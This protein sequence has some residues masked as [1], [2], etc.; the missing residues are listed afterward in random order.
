MIQS[1]GEAEQLSLDY[2]KKANDYQ[3]TI[4]YAPCVS[5]EKFLDLKTEQ[6]AKQN[7]RAPV[8]G[9]RRCFYLL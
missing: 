4:D 6:K 7:R 5:A 3:T 8:M 1:D 9:T 2:W